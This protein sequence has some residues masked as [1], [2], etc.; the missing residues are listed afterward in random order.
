MWVL[1]NCWVWNLTKIVVFKAFEKKRIFHRNFESGRW[2]CTLLG[3]NRIAD[4]DSKFEFVPR[5]SRYFSWLRYLLFKTWICTQM[6]FMIATCLG[7]ASGEG[8]FLTGPWHE[9]QSTSQSEDL[10]DE[11]SYGT[12]AALN[13]LLAF[14]SF[15]ERWF[16]PKANLF[17]L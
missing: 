16:V 8:L 6:D 14:L 17:F 13:G 12:V 7:K 5:W 3:K 15:G 9:K 10:S 11:E 2:N 4:L 1:Q